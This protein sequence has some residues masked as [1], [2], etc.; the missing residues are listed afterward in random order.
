MAVP[1]AHALELD[2]SQLLPGHSEDLQVD[3]QHDEQWQ[4]HTDKEIKVDHVVHVHY[5]LKEALE[6]TTQQ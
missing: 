5:T 2:L 1:V 6:L 4:Q 3:A